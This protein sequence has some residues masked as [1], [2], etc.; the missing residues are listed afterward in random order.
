MVSWVNVVTFS[1][2]HEAHV[3]KT[4]LESEGI[5]VQILNE[6]SSQVYNINPVT[7]GGVKLMV[8]EE[9]YA[10]ACELLIEGGFIVVNNEENSK[11]W[12]AISDKT[13]QLPI[14]GKLPLE[15]RLIILLALILAAIIIPIMT[16][17]EL[18]Q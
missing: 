17:I 5:A 1:F 6:L 2:A 15:V 10:M 12:K 14:I 18:S 13:S 9:Q 3:A 11:F 16:S 7:M 4:K 8:P